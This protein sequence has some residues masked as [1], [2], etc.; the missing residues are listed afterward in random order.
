MGVVAMH[1]RRHPLADACL[2]RQIAALTSDLE[3]ARTERATADRE[4]TRTLGEAASKV[5]ELHSELGRLREDLS[6]SEA[7]NKELRADVAR[8]TKAAECVPHASPLHHTL[9]H[10]PV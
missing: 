3:T 9:P 7:V 5:A 6:V 1:S 8:L 10:R 4:S 2:L